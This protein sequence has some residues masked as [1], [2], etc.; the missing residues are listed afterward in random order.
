MDLDGSGPSRS[1]TSGSR[2]SGLANLGSEEA[3]QVLVTALKSPRGA[4][5]AVAC[6]Q[7][8]GQIADPV[9]VDALATLLLRKKHWFG[10]WKWDD[11]LRATAAMALRQISG[12]E[13][14]KVL[15]R[16]SAEPEPEPR[17]RDVPRATD[18]RRAA[19]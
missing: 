7:A 5:H 14:D 8:L 9:S 10:G 16:A 6:A 13:A 2:L 19:A 11:H 12:P 4:D 18:G 1:S 15:A 17:I 3:A